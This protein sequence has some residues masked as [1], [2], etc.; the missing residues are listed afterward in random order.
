MW[1]GEKKIIQI[2]LSPAKKKIDHISKT[3]NRTKKVI[4]AKNERQINS[5]TP[6][7]VGPAWR[8]LNFWAPKTTLLN[9]RSAQTRY[10]VKFYAHHLFRKLR[11]FYV[12]M[13]TSEGG[14]G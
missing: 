7:K 3:K 5:K 13:A 11:I 14:G 1:E 4:H 10:D 8:K 6:C 9:G 2:L 12:E